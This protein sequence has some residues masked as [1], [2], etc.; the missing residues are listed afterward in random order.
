MSNPAIADRTCRPSL[1]VDFVAM[2]LG[3]V[4]MG[5][6]LGAD[7][8][9]AKLGFTAPSNNV[10]LAIAV[11]VAFLGVNSGVVRSFQRQHF[12]TAGAA[13]VIDLATVP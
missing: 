9:T 13:I 6:K 11:A 8:R 4:W 10:D 12:P 5:R 3:S 7:Y 1:L 2:F